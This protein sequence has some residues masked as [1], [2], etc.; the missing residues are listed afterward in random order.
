MNVDDKIK[1][2]ETRTN[3]LEKEIEQNHSDIGDILAYLRKK[4]PQDFTAGGEFKD[5]II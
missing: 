3:E 5:G 4:Y 2:L 1:G